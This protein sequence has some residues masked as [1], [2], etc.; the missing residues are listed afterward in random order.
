VVSEPGTSENECWSKLYPF[1]NSPALLN[2]RAVQYSS[3]LKTY[4]YHLPLFFLFVSLFP[5]AN[6]P[7]YTNSKTGGYTAII[8]S[9]PQIMLGISFVPKAN[10]QLAFL[11]IY[12]IALVCM[13]VFV[14]IRLAKS[15]KSKNSV[16]RIN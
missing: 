1:L 10:S 12:A 14:F 5:C 8:L 4:I 6:K 16:S 13:L 7:L 11:V 9:V 15:R 3:R 2:S